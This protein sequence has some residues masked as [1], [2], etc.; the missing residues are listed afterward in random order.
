MA[1]KVEVSNFDENRLMLKKELSLLSEKLG[2]TLKDAPRMNMNVTHMTDLISVLIKLSEVVSGI[3]FKPEFKIPEITIPEINVP[4]VHIPEIK[5][6]T[7]YVPPANVTVTPAEVRIDLERVV[8]ALEN[9]KYLSDR[10]NKP[11]A[12]RMTDGQKFTKAI[13]QLQKS[14]EDLGVVYAGNSGLSTDDMR[15]LGVAVPRSGSQKV[16]TVTAGG[17]PHNLASGTTSAGTTTPC[18]KVYLS[19]DTDNASVM[20]VGFTNAVRAASG[21]KNGIVIIPGN[22]PT[23]VEISDLSSMWVDAETNG[24]KLCVAYSIS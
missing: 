18:K 3:D 2:K 9:L 12:V 4:D 20:V 22:N 6:P 7:I 11:L 24:G 21:S 17:T 19:G 1:T 8:K 14:T 16:V 5:I 13:Q 23:E 15:S 10:P